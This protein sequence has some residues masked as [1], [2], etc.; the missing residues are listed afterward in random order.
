MPDGQSVH[1]EGIGNGPTTNEFVILPIKL[2]GLKG[3][4]VQIYGEVH[5]VDTLR[6]G[7]LIGNNI[8]QLWK[9]EICWAC[10]EAD[11]KDVLQI[12]ETYILVQSKSI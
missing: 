1:L 11:R 6:C 10:K 4:P 7:I 8:L 9:M 5:M 12:G 3:Q 2:Q